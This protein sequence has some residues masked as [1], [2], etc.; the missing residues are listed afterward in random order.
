MKV[1]KEVGQTRMD[2]LRQLLGCKGIKVRE[3]RLK[4]LRTSHKD[5]AQ[6]VLAFPPLPPKGKAKP[7]KSLSIRIP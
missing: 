3:R 6:G 4:H 2:T 7:L 1:K 5:S